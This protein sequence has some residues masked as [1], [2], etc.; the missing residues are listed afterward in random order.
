M[1]KYVDN[2]YVLVIKHDLK[3]LAF[4]NN[5]TK[6]KLAVVTFLSELLHYNTYINLPLSP[7][8]TD[9]MRQGIKGTIQNNL[10][11]NSR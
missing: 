2:M 11:E 5:L 7:Q 6:I 8:C 9:L 1:S 10:K 4:T 3:Y